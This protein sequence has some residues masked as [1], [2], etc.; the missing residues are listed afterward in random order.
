M[1]TARERTANRAIGQ[2]RMNCSVWTVS[3]FY[4]NAYWMTAYSPNWMLYWCCAMEIRPN[5]NPQSEVP[6]YRQLGL[7]L[8]RLVETGELRTGDRLPPTRELAGQLGLNR[9][10]ISAAY[11]LLE[12]EGLI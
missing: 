4:P 2:C 11:D 9:T 12:Q 1:S 5:L 10:T 7:Y 8:Q 6:L 3:L